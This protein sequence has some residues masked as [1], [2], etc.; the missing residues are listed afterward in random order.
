MVDRL[1]ILKLYAYGCGGYWSEGSRY[2][3]GPRAREDDLPTLVL[4]TTTTV[5]LLVSGGAQARARPSLAPATPSESVTSDGHRAP[6]GATGDRHAPTC[7]ERTVRSE[8]ARLSILLD[9]RACS[10]CVRP[11]PRDAERCFSSFMTF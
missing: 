5:R 8:G 9:P 4:W 10:G 7:D 6:H 1:D 11:S 2:A 3:T